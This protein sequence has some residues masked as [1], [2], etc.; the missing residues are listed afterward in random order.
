[1]PIA[2]RAD[3]LTQSRAF[4]EYDASLSD[5]QLGVFVTMAEEMINGDLMAPP[6]DG[7]QGGVQ[8]MVTTQIGTMIAGSAVVALPDGYLGT[9]AFRFIN[10]S[11]WVVPKYRPAAALYDLDNS[12]ASNT[13]GYYSVGPSAL[14]LQPVPDSAY[15]FYHDYFGAIAALVGPADTNWVLT[16]FPST[17]LYGVLVSADVFLLDTEAANSPHA[18][19][20]SLAIGRIRAADKRRS[21]PSGPIQMTPSGVT[22][23]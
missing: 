17:Y 5:A 23:A 21:L 4:L 6:E 10:G 14:A 18:K 22:M 12:T 13:P 20:Y 7:G 16:N 11:S 15:Q 1:M 8:F 3:L 2:T 9:K 19:G